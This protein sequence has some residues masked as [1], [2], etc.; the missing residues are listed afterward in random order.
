MR[1]IKGNQA[2]DFQKIQIVSR[3][4][5]ALLSNPTPATKEE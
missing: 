1:A 3:I 2:N 5:R 4:R